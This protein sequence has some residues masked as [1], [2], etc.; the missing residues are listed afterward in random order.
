VDRTDNERAKPPGNWS[1]GVREPRAVLSPQPN[2]DLSGKPAQTPR[3]PRVVEH[4][5]ANQP[6]VD[7]FEADV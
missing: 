5:A 4:R 3:P 1:D 7:E 2:R 6:F